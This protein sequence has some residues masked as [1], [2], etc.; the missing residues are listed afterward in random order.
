MTCLECGGAAK[1][2]G[3]ICLACDGE[4]NLKVKANDKKSKKS[5]EE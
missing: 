4:G 3:E 1:K 2:K 5:K